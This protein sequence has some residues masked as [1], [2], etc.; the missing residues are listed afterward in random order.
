MSA[1]SILVSV[2]RSVVLCILFETVIF[3]FVILIDGVH[4]PSAPAVFMPVMCVAIPPLFIM[5]F[6]LNFGLLC[7]CEICFIACVL[8]FK[9]P[10]TRC[11][12]F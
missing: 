2:K 11:R 6:L 7:L 1:G 8:T 9:D 4:S 10:M 3:T 5:P 12:A